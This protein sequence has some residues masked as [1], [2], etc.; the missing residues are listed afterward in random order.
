MWP[1]MVPI[2]KL[3]VLLNVALGLFSTAYLLAQQT[4][5][6][7]GGGKAVS[8][9]SSFNNACAACHGLD[10][11]GSDKGVNISGSEKVRHFTDAQLSEVI[12][13][14]VPGTGMPA[15]R[16]LSSSQL[17]TLVSYL[18]S[19]QGK[20]DT[21]T[22]AG[23]P[24]HGK[25]IFFG[26]GGCSSCHAISGAGGFLGPDL[27]GYG[28]TS[29]PASIRDE[30]TRERRI[31]RPGYRSV[32]VT[33]SKG[34]HLEGL[35]RNE[36]NFSLQFQSKDGSFHF[37]QKSDLRNIDRQESS[38][39]PSDYGDRLSATELDDLISYLLSSV[40]NTSSTT[41]HKKKED[42]YE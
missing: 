10:G 2:R 34:E 1:R 29:S 33:T 6:A 23:D 16:S 19:L 18:R 38:L 20:S 26:K 3:C 31:P 35:I 32:V 39:M 37:F 22:V 15:F 14:G 42:D 24:K 25:E 12:S 28:N 27:S 40:P 4:S 21:R 30:V 9:R 7:H 41:S 13:N 11:R 17:R 8:G 36:D 5:S